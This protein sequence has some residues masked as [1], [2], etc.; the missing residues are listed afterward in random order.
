MEIWNVKN[1]NN[2]YLMLSG[3]FKFNGITIDQLLVNKNTELIYAIPNYRFYFRMECPVFE[4][5]NKNIYWGSIYSDDAMIYCFNVSNPDNITIENYLP[6]DQDIFKYWV[7]KNG[8]CYYE[9]SSG[10]N[11][12]C[13]GGRIYNCRELLNEYD[14]PW[15]KIFCGTNG[16]FYIVYSKY[17]ENLTK[18]FEIKIIDNNS[19]Q[20]M[21]VTSFPEYIYLGGEFCPNSIRNSC[22]LSNGD[23]IIE[24]DETT[25]ELRKLNISIPSTYDY[26][27]WGTASGNASTFINSESLWIYDETKLYQLKLSDY[28][29]NI[30]DLVSKGYS[31]NSSTITCSINSPGLSFSGV[32]YSD[33]QNIVGTIDEEG[34]ITVFEQTKT[35]NKITTLLRLN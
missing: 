1:L 2:T 34:N 32:R 17:G 22:I 13:P 15:N 33:G 9:T 10:R 5:K 35:S 30:I 14:D 28:S 31:I 23:N 16:N 4:D 18:V 29:L 27:G 21:E 24:F 7:N 6:D 19:L 26:I 20:A 3:Y 8:I 11:F 12:K 25:N